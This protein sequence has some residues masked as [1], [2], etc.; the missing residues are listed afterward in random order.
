MT[1]TITL[2]GHI[3]YLKKLTIMAKAQQG[4]HDEVKAQR[5]EFK[6]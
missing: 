6:C 5:L 4:P 3:L 2:S 1:F